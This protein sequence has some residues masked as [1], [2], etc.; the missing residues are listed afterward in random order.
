MHLEGTIK[1]KD[2][3]TAA[4]GC[5]PSRHKG[6]LGEP[7]PQSGRD[8]L[9]TWTAMRKRL[10]PLTSVVARFSEALDCETVTAD[11]FEVDGSAPNAV[12]CDGMNVYLDVDE[13]DSNET[14][15]VSVAE[16]AVTDSAGNA[17]GADEEV[18]SKDGIPAGISVTVEGTAS[19]DRPVTTKTITVTVTSDERMKGRPT[20]DIRKVG[21]DYTLGATTL[22]GE[23]TSTGTENEWSIEKSLTKPRAC[24]TCT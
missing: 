18:E 24:T 23:A 7:D 2:G 15:D 11:D 16:G 22:G 5:D 12:T 4:I 10:V 17:I 20:V 9:T 19:G 14:P 3:D 8:W 1:A 6:G 13:L 21:D